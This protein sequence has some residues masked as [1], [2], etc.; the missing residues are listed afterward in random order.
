[1]LGHY[2]ETHQEVYLSGVGMSMYLGVA[3]GIVG[4]FVESLLACVDYYHKNGCS[5]CGR[6]CTC[7]RMRRI[8]V[9]TRIGASTY[10]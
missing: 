4:M 9:G 1:M 5:C 10:Q 7:N 8:K 3:L 6:G 2:K